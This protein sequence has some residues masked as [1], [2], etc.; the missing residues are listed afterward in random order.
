MAVR[1]AFAR[2]SNAAA[3]HRHPPFM[4]S[5]CPQTP[6]TGSLPHLS[7]NLQPLPYTTDQV[8]P[9]VSENCQLLNSF[10]RGCSNGS[11]FVKVNSDDTGHFFY[12][13]PGCLRRHKIPPP[14]PPPCFF[15]FFFGTQVGRASSVRACLD[16]MLLPQ[17]Y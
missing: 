9:H 7:C 6:S 5:T 16:A 11:K 8:S 14:P 2:L 12:D 4:P 17:S 3:V 15:F 10:F 13:R 1:N